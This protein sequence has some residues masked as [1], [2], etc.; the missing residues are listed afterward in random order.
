MTLATCSSWSP[1]SESGKTVV[2]VGSTD[3]A[4]LMSTACCVV[5]LAAAIRLAVRSI[6]RAKS[7]A[8]LRATSCGEP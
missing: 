6:V 1:R 3:R 8:F 7:I 2:S 5:S 4:A